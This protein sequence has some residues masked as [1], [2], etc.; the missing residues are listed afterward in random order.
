MVDIGE[1]FAMSDPSAKVRNRLSRNSV[2]F[3]RPTL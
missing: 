3:R 1:S 2:G